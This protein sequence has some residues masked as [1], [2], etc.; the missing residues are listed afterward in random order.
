LPSSFA[1]RF[2][3][4]QHLADRRSVC[5]RDR[6]SDLI[7]IVGGGDRGGNRAGDDQRRQVSPVI[8]RES[9]EAKKPAAGA[10]SSGWPTPHE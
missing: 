7:E 3:R 5:F 10:I 8:Q 2:R 9:S 6:F 4:K 1:S